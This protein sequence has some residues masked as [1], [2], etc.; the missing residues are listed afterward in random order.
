VPHHVYLLHSAKDGKH[1]IGCTN[2]LK[3]RLRRHNRGQVRATKHRTPLRLICS[4]T[5]ETSEQAY[6]REKFLKSWAGRIELTKI[7]KLAGR[8]SAPNAGKLA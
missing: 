2:D 7:L 4:E 3:D 5:F 1:Y 8:G 6:A